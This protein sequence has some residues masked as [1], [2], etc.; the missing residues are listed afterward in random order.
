MLTTY[1]CALF[2]VIFPS[3]LAP[4]RLETFSGVLLL[5]FLVT[6]ILPL[7]N[8]AIFKFFGTISSF[9][10]PELKERH[11]PFV[12]IAL[13]YLLMTFLF[14]RSFRL[15]FSD[16]MMKFLIIVDLLIIGA[17]V[18]TF[19]YKVSVHSL[20]I[21]GAIGVLV[22]LNHDA[23]DGILFYPT[24]ATIVIAGFVMASR[25]Q[26]QVHS[27]REV[28]SG[29]LIGFSIGLVSMIVLF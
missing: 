12:F 6:F 7:A 15:T 22:P 16:S 18:V 26:L 8:V 13:L 2:M 23:A 9:T 1:L 17:T 24:I 3:A 19:F 27:L 14:Y 11:I 21:W 29:G 4:L 25:L 5:V 20:G 10:M 28:M